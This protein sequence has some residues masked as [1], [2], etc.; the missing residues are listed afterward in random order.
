MSKEKVLPL[1]ENILIKIEKPSKKTESG[2]IL[3]DDASKERPQ[4]GVVVEIGTSKEI[5][6]KKGQRVIFR[7]FSGN[8]IKIAQEDYLIIRNEDLLAIVG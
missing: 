1:G 3:P 5:K 8:E 2:I 7:R 4:E 6:V